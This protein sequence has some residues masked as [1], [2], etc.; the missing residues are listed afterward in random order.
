MEVNLGEGGLGIRT[1][2]EG[3][4]GSVDLY[5]KDCGEPGPARHVSLPP[6]L[7][8]VGLVRLQRWKIGLNL[9]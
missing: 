6:H 3:S 5:S 4:P 1:R 2:T 9:L 7:P 8:F